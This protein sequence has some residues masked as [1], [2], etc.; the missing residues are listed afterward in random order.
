MFEKSCDADIDE[1]VQLKYISEQSTS[2]SFDGTRK[3]AQFDLQ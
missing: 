3:H 1:M 2:E